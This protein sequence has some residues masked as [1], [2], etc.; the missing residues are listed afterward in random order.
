M[1]VKDCWRNQRLLMRCARR[2]SQ[3][4]V[5]ARQIT[6]ADEVYAFGLLPLLLRCSCHMRVL[7]VTLMLHYHSA[8]RDNAG[9]VTS[10]GSALLSR[11]LHYDMRDATA[12][13]PSTC[14]TAPPYALLLLRLARHYQFFIKIALFCQ[15]RHCCAQYHMPRVRITRC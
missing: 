13:R 3:Q 6:R 2:W 15:A 8:R 12:M 11:M 14:A 7:A 10:V 4:Y 9:S 1:P 5:F